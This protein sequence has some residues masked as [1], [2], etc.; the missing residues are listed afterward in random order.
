LRTISFLEAY[1]QQ[2]VDLILNIQQGEFNVPITL[3]DQPD[4]LKIPEFYQKKAGDFW[5]TLEGE[6]VAGSIALIDCGDGVGAIRKM[7]VKAEFRGKEKG[8]AAALL[9]NLMQHAKD[10]GMKNVYLGTNALL[11]A[12][13]RFYEK[14]GF[15][16][17]PKE[18]LPA[19]FPLMAVDTIFY[20]IEL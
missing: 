12:S 6:T 15:I 1:Q 17:L 5:I 14:N 4:L 18:E 11:K 9:A 20:G 3:A 10:S 16:A 8:V 2:V 19:Q 13:H 7:F